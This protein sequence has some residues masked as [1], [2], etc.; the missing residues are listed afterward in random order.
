[1]SEMENREIIAL[2]KMVAVMEDELKVYRHVANNIYANKQHLKE[3]YKEIF[4]SDSPENIWQKST[5]LRLMYE[6]EKKNI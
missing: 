5:P 4:E 1:M 3:L 2:K 6:M